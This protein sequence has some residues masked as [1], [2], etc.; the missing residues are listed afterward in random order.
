MSVPEQKD[1]DAWTAVLQNEVNVDDGCCI[2]HSLLWKKYRQWLVVTTKRGAVLY[3]GRWQPEEG[4]KKLAVRGTLLATIESNG[5]VSWCS[6]QTLVPFVTHRKH[7]CF[8]KQVRKL[9]KLSDT[10]WKQL[11]RI[12]GIES[13]VTAAQTQKDSKTA[14]LQIVTALWSKGVFA[15]AFRSAEEIAII[16]DQGHVLFETPRENDTA[17]VARSEKRLEIKLVPL[18]LKCHKLCHKFK[19]VWT[20]V[21]PHGQECACGCQLH[22]SELKNPAQPQ[23]RPISLSPMTQ[24]YNFGLIKDL[25]PLIDMQASV[26]QYFMPKGK[27]IIYADF[28]SLTGKV[29]VFNSWQEAFRFAICRQKKEGRKA[30]Q[31]YYGK[32]LDT[33]KKRIAATKMKRGSLYVAFKRLLDASKRF[34]WTAY[35]IKEEAEDLSVMVAAFADVVKSVLLTKKD[36][37]KKIRIKEGKRKGSFYSVIYKNVYL[38][39]MSNLVVS[40]IS[41]KAPTIIVLDQQLQGSQLISNNE[42]TE[43]MCAM[44]NV[45]QHRMAWL[46]ENYGIE[47]LSSGTLTL[48]GLSFNAITNAAYKNDASALGLEMLGRG[49]SDLLK[50]FTRGGVLFSTLPLMSAGDALGPV[51]EHAATLYEFDYCLAYAATMAK[52]PTATGFVKGFHLALDKEA[53]LLTSHD[54]QKFQHFEFLHT[55]YFLAQ[56][57]ANPSIKIVSCYHKYSPFG[58]WRVANCPLDLVIVYLTQ[59]KQGRWSNLP[60]Y[61]VYNFNHQYTHACNK[62]CPELKSYIAG[63]T[64]DELLEATREVDA[65]H[66]RY[67]SALFAPQ[68]VS[69]ETIYNCHGQDYYTCPFSGLKAKSL[70]DLFKQTPNGWLRGLVE[71]YPREK[72]L[73]MTKLH[74][75]IRNPGIMCYVVATGHVNSVFASFGNQMGYVL[76]RRNGH[77][78]GAHRTYEPT[79]FD[80]ATLAYL[81][82]KRG[83][84][85]EKVYHVLV[86]GTST[87]YCP[88]FERIC[89]AR[90]AQSVSGNTA[91]AS[92][93]K[94]MAVGFI[95]QTQ[96]YSNSAKYITLR[97]AGQPM[98]QYSLQSTYKYDMLSGGDWIKVTR[99]APVR[100]RR[101]IA[102]IIG[103]NTVLQFKLQLLKS[104]MFLEE[105]FRPTAWRLMQI[106]TDSLLLAISGNSIEDIVH[107]ECRDYYE[108]TKH[109]YFSDPPRPG[110]LK[111]VHVY[112]GNWRVHLSGARSKKITTVEEDERG[113]ATS[114][115]YPHDVAIYRHVYDAYSGVNNATLW[116]TLPYGTAFE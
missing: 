29:C 45:L 56:F 110:Y 60:S 28:F 20:F 33:L 13:I 27:E 74:E 103:I 23:C 83:F 71:N 112:C 111:L 32:L 52:Q 68:R 25:Q 9:L 73:S 90:V 62:G 72:V 16:S 67:F 14:V 24:L 22:G 7:V 75:M 15:Q 95:G 50:R 64:R 87:I 116:W 65:V 37:L 43:V 77:L 69:Y 2:V 109:E 49:Y 41:D 108:S 66:T 8:I 91:N 97:D 10:E 39:D 48:Q 36:K 11:L 3:D 46:F 93:L 63:K 5:I 115:N 86:F 94:Y 101:S 6:E 79:L 55:Y 35:N 51:S 44:R 88:Y 57:I 100:K 47:W 105:T 21:K 12:H 1:L 30:R 40:E 26:V 19:L 102:Q 80:G 96:S 18:S 31:N 89:Q 76:T 42:E 114:S 4:E 106:S 70:L 107:P 113:T 84:S 78:T 98:K 59:D 104:V 17:A 53:K 61:A 54:S 99:E 82:D 92:L 38:F 85:I 58:Q 34:M 81:I